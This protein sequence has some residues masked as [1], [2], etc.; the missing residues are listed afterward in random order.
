M[1]EVERLVFLVEEIG[2]LKTKI[3]E[4]I[5]YENYP[6]LDEREI[7]ALR[8]ITNS[9]YESIKNQVLQQLSLYKEI[10]RTLVKK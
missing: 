7:N 5:K 9:L 4:H 6:N 1:T 10:D 3:Q 8:A 2:V